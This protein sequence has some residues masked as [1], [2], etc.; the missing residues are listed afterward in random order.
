VA[1]KGTDKPAG[2]VNN[3]QVKCDKCGT[4]NYVIGSK[5]KS[6]GG[7]ECRSCGHVHR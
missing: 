5:V 3:V 7:W 6:S 2:A 1:Y 4:S